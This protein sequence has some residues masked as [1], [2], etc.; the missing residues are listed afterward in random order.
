M[1]QSST[2]LMIVDD[3]PFN[4]HSLKVIIQQALK[5]LGFAKE[6]LDDLIDIATNGDE[7]LN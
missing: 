4:L 1:L 3:E 7:A 6:Y 5:R 2:R